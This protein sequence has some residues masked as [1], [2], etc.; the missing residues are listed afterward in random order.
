ME[1]GWQKIQTRGVIILQTEKYG[2]VGVLP[3]GM[4]QISSVTVEKE[5]KVG[6]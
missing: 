2:L 1:E 5:V 6:A 3:I 4:S